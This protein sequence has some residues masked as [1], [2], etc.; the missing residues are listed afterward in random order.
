MKIYGTKL[1]IYFTIY[2]AY[3]FTCPGKVKYIDY[4]VYIIFI[5]YI[6]YIK[7]IVF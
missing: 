3:I 5:N 1:G 4:M 7:Y 2:F 6:E